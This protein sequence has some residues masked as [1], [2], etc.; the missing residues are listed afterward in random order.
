MISNKEGAVGMSFHLKQFLQ[1]QTGQM[2]ESFITAGFLSLSGGLQDAYTYISRGQVF[3]NAQ[4][5][6]LVLLGQTLYERHWLTAL[7]YLI[8]LL[9]F[10]L[11][12][13]VAEMIRESFQLAQRLHWRQMVLLL[14]ILILL[15]VGVL[16]AS[17]NLLANA[18][19][20]FACAMQVQTFRKVHGCSFASTMCIGNIR[21]GMEALVKYRQNR[22]TDTLHKAAYYWGI[23]LFFTLGAVLGALLLPRLA[24]HT[25]W[26]S[27]LLLFISFSLMFIRMEIDEAA[28]RR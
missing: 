20:S 8:P 24:M 11:G 26:I 25:I 3:A 5:G 16:P 10:A 23:I 12:V 17:L 22:S 27:C 4:T 6:N 9:F 14:E 28:S 1:G 7:H 2:S 18:M 21:S 15:A 13:A 19:V